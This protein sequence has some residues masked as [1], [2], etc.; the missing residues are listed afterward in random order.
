LLNI[1]ARV[2]TRLGFFFTCFFFAGARAI[3][4]DFR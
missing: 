2:V 3:V 1:N 4:F